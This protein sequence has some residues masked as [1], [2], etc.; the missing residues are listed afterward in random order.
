MAFIYRIETET[1]VN[2]T[3]HFI[4][5][6]LVFIA[7]YIQTHTQNRIEREWEKNNVIY[8]T[9][10]VM[11][12]KKL[13]LKGNRLNSW[14]KFIH[15]C[16]SIFKIFLLWFFPILIDFV[17]IFHLIWGKFIGIF[18]SLSH[19][20]MMKIGKDEKNRYLLSNHRGEKIENRKLDFFVCIL[21]CL[22]EFKVDFCK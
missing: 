8:H 4:N 18:A 5:I 6:R 17:L 7:F 14:G 1:V 13:L 21:D 12:L 9:E 16:D 10:S 22:N 19:T 15:N 20:D 2:K 3:P 11:T